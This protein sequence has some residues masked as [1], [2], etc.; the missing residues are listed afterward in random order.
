MVR[1]VNICQPLAHGGKQGGGGGGGVLRGF[2]VGKFGVG[3][4][5][6]V[7]LAGWGVEA[8]VD[9]GAEVAQSGAV[10]GEGGADGALVD[11]DEAG[12]LVGREDF[13]EG[14]GASVA[15][16]D[17]VALELGEGAF[18]EE[19]V[20]ALFEPL[21]VVEQFVVGEGLGEAWAVGFEGAE[22]VL[23]GGVG[24]L[25]VFGDLAEGEAL[26]SEVVGVEGASA[27][28]GGEA[29][30]CTSVLFLATVSRRGRDGVWF[31]LRW[32][33]WGGAGGQ[34][35][36]IPA[37]ERGYDGSCS[38]WCDGFARAGV[39]DSLAGVWRV[40][41]RGLGVAGCACS[42]VGGGDGDWWAAR[43]DT[44]GGARV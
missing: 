1:G 44:R 15:V 23:D 13:V 40:R 18:A 39:T 5:G 16:A 28:L 20:E 4:V 8:L 22:V 32:E 2:W 33:R 37:A 10:F 29:H 27:A 24:D 41:L 30:W 11:V 6:V 43:R 36:E 38:R 35:G 25:E 17:G 7:L 42:W 3:V 14:L 34:R 26:L 21:D 9:G 31:R 19:L 12:D